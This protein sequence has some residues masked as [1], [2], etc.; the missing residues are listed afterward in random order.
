MYDKIQHPKTQKWVSINSKVGKQILDNYTSKI[1]QTGGVLMDR[2]IEIKKKI[3]ICLKD[4]QD[5]ASVITKSR[6]KELQERVAKA[7]AAII[8]FTTSK[9]KDR[10]GDSVILVEK[11]IHEGDR[12]VVIPPEIIK[13]IGN[14]DSV[15][16]NVKFYV[17]SIKLRFQLSDGIPDFITLR[18]S[19]SRRGE[20]SYYNSREPETTPIAA[21]DDSYKS[22][23]DNSIFTTYWTKS[24]PQQRPAAAPRPPAPRPVPRPAAAA[25]PPRGAAA[26]AADQAARN[27]EASAAPHLDEFEQHSRRPRGHPDPA[28]R[29]G[30]QEI[31]I[32]GAG[33]VGLLMT[34]LLLKGRG[35]RI[36]I[37]LWENRPFREI[38]TPTEKSVSFI[39]RANVMFLNPYAKV[40]PGQP[41]PP[42]RRDNPLLEDPFLRDFLIQNGLCEAEKPPWTMRG[43]R[44]SNPAPNTRSGF[45]TPGLPAERDRAPV[46]YTM[47]I[48]NVQIS[49]VQAI[50]K[51]I[52]D[53]GH[54]NHPGPGP[55]YEPNRGP[56][57]LIQHFGKKLAGK[58]DWATINLPP[59]SIVIDATGGRA[60][61]KNNIFGISQIRGGNGD[62]A[63][64]FG[65]TCNIP[66][67]V[68]PMESAARRSAARAPNGEDIR[69]HNW[70][71]LPSHF[72][73][74]RAGSPAAHRC[75][76]YS[77][78][79][80]L[81]LNLRQ[82]QTS[83]CD[84]RHTKAEFAPICTADM[85]P[86]WFQ[87]KIITALLENGFE[88]NRG[89]NRWIS[90]GQDGRSYSLTNL[91][92]ENMKK[93]I[94]STFPIN[95]T[96]STESYKQDRNI[97][98]FLVGDSVLNVHFFSGTG[99]N[100][101]LKMAGK[102]S[103]ALR[104][105]TGTLQR[106]GEKYHAE[107]MKIAS[108]GVDS[109]CGV[110][111]PSENPWR[112]DSRCVDLAAGRGDASEPLN[113]D[114]AFAHKKY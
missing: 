24:S 73:P 13:I 2:Y 107:A 41:P 88:I 82:W 45:G 76:D 30:E 83:K 3:D 46:G 101:G 104:A 35:I 86:D 99:I 67:D 74:L 4:L 94:I 54:L 65:A 72:P 5:N 75:V 113:L 39:N 93:L 29:G 17:D 32:L 103:E 84:T 1:N 114:N 52:R 98:Y 31:H 79:L 20:W 109:S 59:N 16:N 55:R 27:F 19:R 49:L 42:Q 12:T 110:V 92:K 53:S 77:Y 28:R 97:H 100:S 108:S 78:Y 80:G 33:P 43:A 106:A 68:L 8:H 105:Q 25:A 23:L 61:I 48:N 58:D 56:P 21:N 22:I 38:N 89:S 14:I 87:R 90:V 111:V 50:N 57:K 51:L 40:T 81:S 11:Y 85:K 95:I 64:A 15:F 96:H 47:P 71:M 66:C 34:Y 70:R 26:Q 37:N 18:L 6:F 91:G 63:D 60:G 7:R 10:Y 9:S 62:M 112:P 69:Q 36:T 44:C 102:L